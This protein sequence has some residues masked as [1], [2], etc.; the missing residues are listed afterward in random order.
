MAN[1]EVALAADDL[2]PYA[3]AIV[4][5]ALAVSKSSEAGDALSKLKSAAINSGKSCESTHF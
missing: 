2:D 5:Y 1:L 4:T 3:L